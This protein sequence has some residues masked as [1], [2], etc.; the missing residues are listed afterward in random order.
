MPHK[1]CQ[2]YR[3]QLLLLFIKLFATRT[4]RRHSS[5]GSFR[6]CLMLSIFRMLAMQIAQA[7]KCCIKTIYFFIIKII[8]PASLS[9]YF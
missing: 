6:D 5:S 4:H 7:L 8:F 1:T 2:L 9:S 3:S